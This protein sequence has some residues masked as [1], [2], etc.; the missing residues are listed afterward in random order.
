MEERENAR[1]AEPAAKCD[2]VSREAQGGEWSALARDLMTQTRRLRM[3]GKGAMRRWDGRGRVGVLHVLHHSDGALTAGELA[4]ACHVTSA[5]M[6]QTLNQLEADGLI[7]RTPSKADRRR[8]NVTITASGE[9]ELRSYF[10]G[11]T[12]FA[13]GLLRQLGEKDSRELVRILGRLADVLREASDDR[14]TGYGDG[15]GCG[16]GAGEG[17]AHEAR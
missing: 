8:T 15:A 4:R 9:A 14:G 16:D 2:A 12:R 1:A 3:Y 7:T 10:D 17:G 11:V 13:A 6:A 5:R